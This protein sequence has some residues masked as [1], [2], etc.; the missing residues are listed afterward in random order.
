MVEDLRARRLKLESSVR[1]IADDLA[2]RRR[3][4]EDRAAFSAMG[5][6]PDTHPERFLKFR[7]NMRGWTSNPNDGSERYPEYTKPK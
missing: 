3:R 1:S 5:K 7:V 6:D 4:E 2:T